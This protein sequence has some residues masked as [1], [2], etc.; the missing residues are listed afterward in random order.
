LEELP[1][2]FPKY[3]DTYALLFDVLSMLHHEEQTSERERCINTI[4]T[5]S[6]ALVY[7]LYFGNNNKLQREIALLLGTDG[8]YKN[9]L[10]I[11]CERMKSKSI[12]LEASKVM[13]LTE[14]QQIENH[15]NECPAKSPR[16]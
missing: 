4:E 13:N 7:D 3:P 5:I 15:L 16:Y 1:I 8:T 10:I 9:D 6:E 14:V 2:I 11:L 12:V